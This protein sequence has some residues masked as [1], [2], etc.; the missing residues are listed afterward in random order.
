MY[1]NLIVKDFPDLG[2]YGERI[3]KAAEVCL[4]YSLLS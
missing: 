2:E 3:D 4:L 1:I